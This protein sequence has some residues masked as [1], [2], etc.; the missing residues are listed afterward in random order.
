MISVGIQFKT[1]PAHRTLKPVFQRVGQSACSKNGF[2][3]LLCGI[4]QVFD[5]QA[6]Q[7]TTID[8]RSGD[9]NGVDQIIGGTKLMRVK[10]ATLFASQ[11]RILFNGN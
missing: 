2:Q 1:V 5:V 10:L 9:L 11:V 3:R 7:Y 8:L 6:M 4:A